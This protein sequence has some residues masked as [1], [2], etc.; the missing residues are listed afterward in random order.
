[1]YMSSVQLDKRGKKTKKKKRPHLKIFFVALQ[2]NDLTSR[3]ILIVHFFNRD[4]KL[5]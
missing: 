5:F 4:L 2:L 1:M 3:L